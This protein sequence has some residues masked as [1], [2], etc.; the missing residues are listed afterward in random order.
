MLN[1]DVIQDI[2]SIIKLISGLQVFISLSVGISIYSFNN[3]IKDKKKKTSNIKTQDNYH[4]NS[5]NNYTPPYPYEKPKEKWVQKHP[6]C[7]GIIASILSYIIIELFKFG[8]SY[9][10]SKPQLP[11]EPQPLIQEVSCKYSIPSKN[12]GY[13]IATYK[14]EIRDSKTNEIINEPICEPKEEIKIETEICSTEED[15]QQ[16]PSLWYGRIEFIKDKFGNKQTIKNSKCYDYPIQVI[17]QFRFNEEK[18]P[19]IPNGKMISI[20]ADGYIL[21]PNTNKEIPLSECEDR[22]EAEL[23]VKLDV[24]YPS[25]NVVRD[26]PEKEKITYYIGKRYYIKEDGT[27]QYIATDEK[28]PELKEY[29]MPYKTTDKVI[30]YNATRKK[31]GYSQKITHYNIELPSSQGKETEEIRETFL[32]ETHQKL[33]SDKAD[34]GVVGKIGSLKK[35]VIVSDIY[36]RPDGKRYVIKERMTEKLGVFSQVKESALLLFKLPKR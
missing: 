11:P 20:R 6:I 31:D 30:H 32:R 33:K 17:R 1:L 21:N 15:L 5:I 29:G 10:F 13:A 35:C 7:S 36:S 19:S 14:T 18:C 4:N 2:T 22:G 27:P 8:Y 9:F 3:S 12:H 26:N 16:N 25:E 28:C 24:C 23:F 34:C